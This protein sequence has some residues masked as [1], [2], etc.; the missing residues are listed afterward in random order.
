MDILHHLYVVIDFYQLTLQLYI[1]RIG[2]FYTLFCKLF[3][4]CGFVL[5]LILSLKHILHF[6]KQVER[7][8]W[9]DLYEGVEEYL[10]VLNFY[11]V[12]IIKI[13]KTL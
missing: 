9:W 10:G 13:C 4:L 6:Q 2:S 12:A 3:K 7:L 5:I 8:V 11:K 1:E